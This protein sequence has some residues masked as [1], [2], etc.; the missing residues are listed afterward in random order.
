MFSFFPN[1][2][3]RV[4]SY[5]AKYSIAAILK[6]LEPPYLNLEKT[7]GAMVQMLGT[8]SAGMKSTCQ[9]HLAFEN[10]SHSSFTVLRYGYYTDK[11]ILQLPP[12]FCTEARFAGLEPKY[13]PG[14]DMLDLSIQ[15]VS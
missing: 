6:F 10:G 15:L 12:A 1:S 7:E 9:A 4:L 5:R 2:H 11:I 14:P 13:S 3:L 8:Q